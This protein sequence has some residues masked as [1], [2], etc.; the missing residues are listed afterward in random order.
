M[1]AGAAYIRGAIKEEQLGVGVKKI[2]YI[3]EEDK[4]FLTKEIN[5]FLNVFL[6]ID[7]DEV[8]NKKLR[9]FEK[10][11]EKDRDYVFST[12]CKIIPITDI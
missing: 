3:S 2:D 8:Y 6:P 5:D 4:V 11:F 7:I 12:F 9:A 10:L 1:T